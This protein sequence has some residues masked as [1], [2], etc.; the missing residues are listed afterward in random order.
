MKVGELAARLT[1][2][3]ANDPDLDVRITYDEWRRVDY[4]DT[5]VPVWED[6]DDVRV[7]DGVVY[8]G[9]SEWGEMGDLDEA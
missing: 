1:A 4:L 2:L 7:R 5:L 8:V 9:C 6:A 3:A